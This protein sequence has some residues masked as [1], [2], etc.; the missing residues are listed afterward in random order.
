MPATIFFK[1]TFMVDMFEVQNSQ[2]L[3]SYWNSYFIIDWITLIISL[4]WK[5]WKYK[6]FL[7]QKEMLI[8]F[9]S[10][11]SMASWLSPAFNGNTSLI[12]FLHIFA[13]KDLQQNCWWWYGRHTFFFQ[14]K[15]ALLRSYF[16]ILSLILD[17]ICL[18]WLKYSIKSAS[19]RDYCLSLKW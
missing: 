7:K 13:L 16:F 18:P 2:I 4:K 17:T 1:W 6:T 14:G 5:G 11:Y 8:I 9:K 15:N 12:L 3:P 19:C 10:I